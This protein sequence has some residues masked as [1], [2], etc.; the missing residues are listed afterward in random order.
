VNT[1]GRND[2]YFSHYYFITNKYLF[3]GYNDKPK[4]A[5]ITTDHKKLSRYRRI[6]KSVPVLFTINLETGQKTK[7]LFFDGKDESVLIEPSKT[8]QN[9]CNKDVLFVGSKEKK[10]KYG[11]IKLN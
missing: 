10:I 4:N 6:A 7:S 5:V 3:V 9:A 8:F 2:I 1:V 11:I